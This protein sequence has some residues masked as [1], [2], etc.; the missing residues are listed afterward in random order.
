MGD[1][2]TGCTSMLSAALSMYDKYEG[3]C[4]N[5]YIQQ[6]DVAALPFAG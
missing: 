1:A 5:P 4:T 2:S 3:P 6:Q